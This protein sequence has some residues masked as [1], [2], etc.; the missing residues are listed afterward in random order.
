MN[1]RLHGFTQRKPKL[2][3]VY[4]VSTNITVLNGPRRLTQGWDVAE[5][6]FFAG[7]F[8]NV[9][10]CNEACAH[11][12]LTLLSGISRAWHPGMWI[13]GPISPIAA[14]AAPNQEAP[15]P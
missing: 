15:K 5:I 9:H 1:Y 2:P 11:W 3:G 12:R 6:I 10:D 7:S 13:K 8:S 14:P 4:F